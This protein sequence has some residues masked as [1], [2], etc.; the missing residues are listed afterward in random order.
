MWLAREREPE[1]TARSAPEWRPRADSR[2]STRFT[3]RPVALEDR[4]AVGDAHHPEEAVDLPRGRTR[5]PAFARI[6]AQAPDTA[7]RRSGGRSPRRRGRRSR[8]RARARTRRGR[9]GRRGSA[10]LP[11]SGSPPASASRC[12][13]TSRDDRLA[14]PSFSRSLADA[15]LPT[16]DRTT[17]AARPRPGRPRRSPRRRA[18]TAVPPHELGSRRP[19]SGRPRRPAIALGSD[20]LAPAPPI[21]SRSSSPSCAAPDRAREELR[22]PGRTTTR[23]PTCVDDVRRLA[24]GLRRRRSPAGRPR[25]RRRGGS[26]RR[27]PRARAPARRRARPRPRASRRGAREP[28]SP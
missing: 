24:L 19:G 3:R 22:P 17:S 15:A 9:A 4:R 5:M 1:T 14:C 20:E 18:V 8:R 10:K 11:R 23:Q 7:A 2:R 13:P 12:G 25:G 28:G 21:A 16:A 26:G 6:V 27:S